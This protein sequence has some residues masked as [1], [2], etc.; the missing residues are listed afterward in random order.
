MVA[1]VVF[2]QMPFPNLNLG[3]AT[4]HGTMINN[5]IA[6]AIA[7]TKASLVINFF[8]GV[9]YATKLTKL[10]AMAGFVGFSLMFLV[11]GD[12]STRKNEPTPP[13]PADPVSS[14]RRSLPES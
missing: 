9:K 8:M 4:L 3:F 2:A 14:M 5:I 7:V 13:W 12:Y 1:T 10:W 11:F 6:M